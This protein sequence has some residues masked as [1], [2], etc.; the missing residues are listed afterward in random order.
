M[1]DIGDFISTPAHWVDSVDP[2]DEV[3]VA[4]GGNDLLDVVIDHGCGVDGVPRCDR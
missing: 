1:A 3:E 2:G 4:V